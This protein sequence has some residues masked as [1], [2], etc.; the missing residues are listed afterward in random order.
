MP[1]KANADRRHR[2]PKQ[3]RRITNW[4]EY[5]AFFHHLSIEFVARIGGLACRDGWHRRTTPSVTLAR[6]APHHAGR[7]TALLVSGDHD[8]VDAQGRIPLGPAPDRRPDRLPHPSAWSRSLRS[9][10]YHLEPQGGE[11]GGAAS[12]VG[13]RCQTCAPAGGQHGPEALR[14]RGVADREAWH[15][16][17]SVL[18]Q[19]AHRRGC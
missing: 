3:R 18:A 19:A 10:P 6:R 16:G 4:A 11:L 9:R 12:A 15:E 8:G 5:D 2:I 17:A 14:A 7:S 13:Q 1:F